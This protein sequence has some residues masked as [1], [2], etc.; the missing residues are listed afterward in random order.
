MTTAHRAV[1][2]IAGVTQSDGTTASNW[3][4]MAVRYHEDYV[5]QNGEWKFRRVRVK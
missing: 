2:R 1:N 3:P 4:G 5:K